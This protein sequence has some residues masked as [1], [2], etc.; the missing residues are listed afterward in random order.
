M[1]KATKKL[2]ATETGAAVR[3]KTKKGQEYLISQNPLPPRPQD[4]FTLWRQSAQGLERVT[5]GKEPTS[6]YEKI[7]WDS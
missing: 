5:S 1:A 7:P 3:C 2:P 4:R 6:L